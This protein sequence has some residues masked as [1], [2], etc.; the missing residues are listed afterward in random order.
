MA[1]ALLPT[2]ITVPANHPTN[3]SSAFEPTIDTNIPEN[4]PT[5]V[6][7]EPDTTTTTYVYANHYTKSSSVPDLTP[8]PTY[9]SPIRDTPS[10]TTITHT[11][12]SYFHGVK[13][14]Y[15]TDTIYLDEFTSLQ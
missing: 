8:L 2:T 10:P 14:Y 6:L 15:S 1:P 12:V 11:L 3:V 13:W 7:P 5:P 9:V 4:P